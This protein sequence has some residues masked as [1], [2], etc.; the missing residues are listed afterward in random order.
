MLGVQIKSS[1]AQQNVTVTNFS[2]PHLLI[3]TNGSKKKPLW[4]GTENMTQNTDDTIHISNSTNQQ[5][6]EST[7][8]TYFINSL[9][10]YNLHVFQVT[11][12]GPLARLPSDLHNVRTF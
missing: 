11:R 8:H 9:A 7:N 6:I 4:L 5:T 10:Q 1:T 3:T 2:K 12:F